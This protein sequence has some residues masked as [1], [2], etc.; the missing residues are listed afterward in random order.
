MMADFVADVAV[1]GMQLLQFAGELGSATGPVAP[2]G[3]ASDGFELDA[4]FRRAAETARGPRAL[5]FELI[6]ESAL[7][8]R[9][10]TKAEMGA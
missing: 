9:S 3:G 2:S 6:P 10:R 5:P 7:S 8:R 1:I 4:W